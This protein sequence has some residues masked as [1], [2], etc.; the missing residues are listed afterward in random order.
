MLPPLYLFT[1][2]QTIENNRFPPTLASKKFR[3]LIK[4]SAQNYILAKMV[5]IA[6]RLKS[7]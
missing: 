5:F 1:I 3:Q 4:N 7:S 2:F 6:A